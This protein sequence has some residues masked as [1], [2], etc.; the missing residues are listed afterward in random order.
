MQSKI[1]SSLLTPWS[2]VVRLATIPLENL[3]TDVD[4]VLTEFE[5][6]VDY[7]IQFLSLTT[8]DYQ[9]VWWCL[10]NC[11]NSQEWKNGLNLVELFFSLPASNGKVERIFS[12]LKTIKSEK[13]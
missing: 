11:P 6:M 7:A 8:M 5:E 3:N 10:F 12:Q 2:S 9:A 1:S 13:R 4:T